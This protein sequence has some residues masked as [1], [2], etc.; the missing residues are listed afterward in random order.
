MAA[1]QNQQQ[2]QEDSGPPLFQG[3][4]YGAAAFVVGYLLTYFL[5]FIED[6]TEGENQ[7]EGVGQ[8]FFNAQLVGTDYG[9]AATRD[10]LEMLAGSPDFTLPAFL[11]TLVIGVVITG[12]GYALTRS[13]AQPQTTTDEG[14]VIGASILAGY[15]PLSFLGALLFEIS[16]SGFSSSPDIFGA[17]LL[18]GIVFPALLGAIGGYLAIR[19]SGAE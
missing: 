9:E 12:S 3:A 8:I 5:L 2:V 4:L 13:M 11:F 16:E 14:T 18:A 6:A 19:T 15:L 10:G 17:V 1:Q 7:I